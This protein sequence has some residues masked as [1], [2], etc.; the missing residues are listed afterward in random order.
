MRSRPW[1]VWLIVLVGVTPAFADDAAPAGAHDWRAPFDAF[2]AGRKSLERLGIDF[3]LYYNQLLSWKMTG[4]VKPGS[5]TGSS[6]SYDFLTRVDLEELAGMRG[7]DLLLHVKGMYDSNVNDDVGALYQPLDDAD[8]DQDIY[9]SQLWLRQGLFDDRIQIVAGFAEQQV[10]YDRNAYANSEDR[11]FMNAALDNN[12]LVP[13]PNG[14]TAI[15]I[16]APHPDFELAIG[17]VDADNEPRNAGF[18]TAFDGPRSLTALAEATLHLALGAQNELP[19]AIRVGVFRDG[20]RLTRFGDTNAFGDPQQTR[21]HLGVWV[22]ADQA[23]IRP[24]PGSRP[25]LGVFGRFG[26]ADPDVN[27][28][29]WFWSLGGE[30]EGALPFRERDALGVAFYRADGS[31]KYRDEVDPDF[32]DETGVEIYYRV[33]VTS[34]LAVTPDLQV[35]ID[36]GAT[37]RGQDA[38]LGTLRLRVS[39]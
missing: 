39:F 24:V 19:G 38:V 22:S 26:W 23:L 11:Q 9:V 8:F 33:D 36:P 29:E 30:I 16:L 17:V 28:V 25:G 2:V 10:F 7:L 14:M 18:D 5:N 6:A 21:G 15:L 32:D 4:G 27:R 20:R 34:W 3:D 13:L 35:V 31:P 37:G 12:P 1:L